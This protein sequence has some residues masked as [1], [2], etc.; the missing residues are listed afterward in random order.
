LVFLRAPSCP[1]WLF[2]LV[3]LRVLRVLRVKALLRGEY[4]KTKAG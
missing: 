3:L 2:A 1:S 4:Q